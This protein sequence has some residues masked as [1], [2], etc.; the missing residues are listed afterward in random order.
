MNEV[1]VS[2]SETLGRATIGLLDQIEYLKNRIEYLKKENIALK[3]SLAICFFIFVVWHFGISHYYWFADL[4]IGVVL[5]LWLLD[6]LY[7]YIKYSKLYWYIKY[8]YRW[9]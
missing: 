4:L 5:C 7:W 8:K 6:K 1:L 9:D 2:G 3:A